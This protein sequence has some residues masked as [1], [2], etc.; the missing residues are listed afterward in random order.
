MQDLSQRTEN[1]R[2]R[3]PVPIPDVCTAFVSVLKLVVEHAELWL[4]GKSS[5]FDLG[6]SGHIVVSRKNRPQMGNLQ[7]NGTV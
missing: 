7:R 4:S 5:S 6:V 2:N 3:M 1:L